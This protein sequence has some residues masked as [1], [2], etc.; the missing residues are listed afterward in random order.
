MISSLHCDLVHPVT[1]STVTERGLVEQHLPPP[2]EILLLGL[3]PLRDAVKG[4]NYRDV[5][6]Y[7]VRDMGQHPVVQDHRGGC[8]VTR[9]HTDEHSCIWEPGP[10]LA[11]QPISGCWHDWPCKM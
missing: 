3:A 6:G 11:A 5:N 10:T 2:C 7:G 8:A 4:R 9:G 1:W